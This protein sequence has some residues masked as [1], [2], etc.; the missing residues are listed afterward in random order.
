MADDGTYSCPTSKSSIKPRNAT[1]NKVC[2]HKKMTQIAQLSVKS[3]Y[4]ELLF[5]SN[6]SDIIVTDCFRKNINKPN[7]VLRGTSTR[8][9][10]CSN[11]LNIA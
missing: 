4:Y 8:F 2:A 11:D 5:S 10:I 3:V 9:Q 7:S 6:T 1:G